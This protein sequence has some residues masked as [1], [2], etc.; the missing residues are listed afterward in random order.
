MGAKY[1]LILKGFALA[2]NAMVW[3]VLMRQLLINV[4]DVK[5]EAC[6]QL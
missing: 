6:A 3:E 4:M 1:K 5:V 2:P